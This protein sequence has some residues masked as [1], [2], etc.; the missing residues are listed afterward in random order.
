MPKKPQ[1]QKSAALAD[2]EL[3]PDAWDRFEDFITTKVPNR[4]AA[5]PAPKPSRAKTARTKA[6]KTA[7]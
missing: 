7:R 4:P 5:A 2:I 6:K 1:D 3:H